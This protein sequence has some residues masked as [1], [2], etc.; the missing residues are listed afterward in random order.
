ML[1]ILSFFS[2]VMAD[3]KM[4]GG[5][6][7]VENFIVY[8]A[9]GNPDVDIRNYTLII[10]GMVEEPA[11]LTFQVLEQMVDSAYNKDFHC[12]TKWS[13][14]NVQ[15]TGIKFSTLADLVK[16]KKEASW[17]MFYG[18]DGYTTPVPLE[19][20]MAPESMVAI[21]MNDKP[22]PRE[23][24]YPARP[25]IPQLYGWKSAKWL[26]RIEFLVEYRN[27]YWESY[28]Y[29]ERGN[30]WNEERF[31]GSAWKKVKKSVYRAE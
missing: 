9:M 13:V 2:I 10:D 25:F 4:P 29:H 1:I 18:L 7:F 5:Q 23:N 30:V 20:A 19:D 28:G 12:V 31:K 16:V 27:G 8:S 24:G 15:W 6:R 17:V 14:K 3:P 22:I 26:H 21:R 11:T